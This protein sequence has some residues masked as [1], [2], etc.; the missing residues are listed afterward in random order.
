VRDSEFQ[1]KLASLEICGVRR[2]GRPLSQILSRW[3]KAGEVVDEEVPD[4]VLG[5]LVQ[6][7]GRNRDNL[8]RLLKVK[9]KHFL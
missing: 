2:P 1:R 7:W 8:Q 6:I 9:V 5:K 3:L 4:E